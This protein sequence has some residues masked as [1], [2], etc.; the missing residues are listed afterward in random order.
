MLYYKEL[1]MTKFN[2]LYEQTILTSQF[3]VGDPVILRLDG[4]DIEAYVR[5]VLFTNVKVRYSVKVASEDTTLHNIDSV[6]IIPDNTR[7][8][9]EFDYVDNYS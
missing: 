6:F 7:E 1:N 4:N 5:V 8:P 2:K 9:I 3:A